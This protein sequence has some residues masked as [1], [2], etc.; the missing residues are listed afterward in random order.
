LKACKNRVLKKSLLHKTK[1]VIGRWSKLHNDQFRNSFSLMNNF[2]FIESSTPWVEHVEYL[3][4]NRHLYRILVGESN[5]IK[6][7]RNIL[8]RGTNHIQG[9]KSRLS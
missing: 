6:H 7:L 5:R 4:F 9:E 8:T 2:R 1:E 3:A